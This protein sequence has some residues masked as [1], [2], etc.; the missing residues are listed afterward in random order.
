[1]DEQLTD[2]ESQPL[3]KDKSQLME[4][5]REGREA[6]QA[7][8]GRLSEAELT[9]P[10]P[11]DG[12]SVKDHLFH[13]AVWERSLTALLQ[14]RPRHAAMG[15]DAEAY[16][17]GADA[18]NALVYQRNSGRSLSEARAEFEQSHSDLLD[19]L[20]GLT[21]EDLFRTYSHY[22]P[23]EPGEDSGAPIVGWIAG[24]SYEHY[25]EHQA[26]IEALTQ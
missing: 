7:I 20:D 10:G 24:N 18:I 15:V 17:R 16:F 23:D 6:L 21:N 12:W 3:P 9:T 1:M 14:G 11:P 26:W 2:A 4:R 13:V 5:I 22:Q 8:I 25:F 19:V